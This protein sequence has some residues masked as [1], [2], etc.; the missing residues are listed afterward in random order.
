MYGSG[1][2]TRSFCFVSDLVN[3]LIKLM[4][5]SDEITGPINIGNP[6][7]FTIKELAHE[8]IRK[9]NSK[10]KIEFKEIPPDDPK[11]RKPDITKAQTQLKWNPSI[12]LDEGLSLT[13]QYFK[14]ILD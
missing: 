8:I 7:E 4:D 14:D 13:I 3:G 6:N 12:E 2:Q 1:S 11:Q 5:S 10:S 9:T